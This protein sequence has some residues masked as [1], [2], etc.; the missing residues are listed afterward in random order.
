[1]EGLLKKRETLVEYGAPLSKIDLEIA[2]LI[3]KINRQRLADE[4]A[5]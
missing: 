1:M 2:D 5:R 3:G 4:Q